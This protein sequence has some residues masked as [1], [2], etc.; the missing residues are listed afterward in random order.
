MAHYERFLAK[1][2]CL[3][4]SLWPALTLALTVSSCL[5]CIVERHQE[6][7]SLVD[8]I[9]RLM[10]KSYPPGRPGAAVLV[11]ANGHV[12][13]S[14]GYGLAN[15]EWNVPITPQT[16]FR[17]GSIT[18]QFT[19]LSI[20]L[21]VKDGRISLDDPIDKY[22]PA[23]R[24]H[25]I[26]VENLLTHTSGL[27]S[28]TSLD[29]YNIWSR[30][31]PTKREMLALLA[32]QP[33]D[34]APG[35]DWSYSDSGYY[36][37]GLIIEKISGQSYEKFLQSRIFQPLSMKD[38]T[39]DLGGNII[40]RR[41]SGY[42]E[43]G[44]RPFNAPFLSMGVPYSAGWLASNTEDLAKWDN[45]LQSKG[46]AGIDLITKMFTPFKL[47]TGRLTNYG[48]AWFI[49]DF[50]GYRFVEHGGRISGFE[51]HV[52]KVP[53]V[54][55]FI[56]VLSNAADHEPSVDF[57]ATEIATYVLGKPYTPV[58]KP[59]SSATSARLVG[60]YQ[61]E[62][63]SGGLRCV[64]AVGDRLFIKKNG[65]VP[66]EVFASG[67]D[68]FFLANSFDTLRLFSDPVHGGSGLM[69]ESKYWPETF[70]RKVDNRVGACQ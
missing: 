5:A 20:L 46:L 56:A 63:E 38:T 51:A 9:D 34:F 49:H 27:P 48:Y 1:R 11:K 22:L 3:P 41:A 42:I 53:S 16:V 65:G 68:T 32:S 19:A 37:L 13:F 28:Y 64:E 14:K 12:I 31:D 50:Y 59:I 30:L 55:L 4:R 2:G 15:A 69:V 24:G 58:S 39:S 44:N 21:L 57:V 47:K 33:S 54:D 60:A 62:G 8:Q 40:P 70:A 36:V 45:A 7:S 43:R 18:K 29:G 23:F 10:S 17:L 26:T 61:L 35:N 52:L 66:R 6:D 67:L 25:G